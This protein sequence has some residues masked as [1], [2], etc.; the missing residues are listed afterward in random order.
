VRLLAM[1]YAH[2][3]ICVVSCFGGIFGGGAEQEAEEEKLCISEYAVC[4]NNAQ[5]LAVNIVRW[6]CFRKSHSSH[7]L[8]GD[9]WWEPVR[10]RPTWMVCFQAGGMGAGVIERQR[11]RD[12]VHAWLISYHGE[13]SAW[14]QVQEPSG[15]IET[16]SIIPS[17]SAN[18]ETKK[19]RTMT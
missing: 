19:A 3:C 6:E 12:N 16:D 4:N 2:V 18:E 5:K 1:H 9:V 10:L 13:V 7:Y 8:V 15:S 11:Q 17:L 14:E